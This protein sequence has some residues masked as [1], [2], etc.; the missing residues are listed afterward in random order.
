MTE[1]LDWSPK[2]RWTARAA[3]NRALHKK[4]IRRPKKCSICGA[5][6]GVDR[7]G[8]SKIHGYHHKGYEDP[9]KL[10]IIWVCISCRNKMVWA[11]KRTMEAN[12]D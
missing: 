1:N 9:H 10:N 3:L 5:R 12:H 8:N 2:G 4:K 7:Q 6:P 11:R